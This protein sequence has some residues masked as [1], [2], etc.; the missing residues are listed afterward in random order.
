MKLAT[1]YLQ[2]LA[3]KIS[4]VISK[5]FIWIP[6]T[7]LLSLKKRKNNLNSSYSTSHDKK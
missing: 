2:P 5:Q 6:G 4:T 3:V 7:G 1:K